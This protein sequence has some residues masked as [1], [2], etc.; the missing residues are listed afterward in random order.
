M[1]TS[2]NCAKILIVEDDP[3]HARL[4][5]K[6]L[7]RENALHEIVIVHDGQK[8]IDYF[9]SAVEGSEGER[10]PPTVVLL[11]LHLPIR[12]GF[13]VLEHVKSNERTR[14]TPVFVLTNS[15]SAADATR[16]YELGC[17]VFITK[18]PDYEM[19][20]QTIRSLG[21]FIS[22]ITCPRSEV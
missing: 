3:G 19:F 9:S 16:C 20:S 22:V 17:N 8:A 11:D 13:Q 7:M 14:L 6:N 1:N 5:E 21:K 10:T 18:P 2:S 15:D 12:N 4:M